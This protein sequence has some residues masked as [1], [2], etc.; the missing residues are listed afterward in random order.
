MSHYAEVDNNN[1]V[2]RVLVVESD[3]IQRGTFG[4]PSN[5]IKTSY[6]MKGGVYHDETNTPAKDQSV[7][8]GDKARQRKNYAGVGFTYDK[9]MD[10]FIPPNPFPSWILNKGTCLWDAPVASPD[11]GKRYTWD[12]PNTKWIEVSE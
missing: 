6:N 4:E 1:I 9:T 8:N 2:Q 10:A 12:E 5:W 11:D 7:I 3:V